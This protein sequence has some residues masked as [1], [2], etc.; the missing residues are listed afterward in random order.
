MTAQDAERVLCYS[1]LLD[2]TSREDL[3]ARHPIYSFSEKLSWPPAN[4]ASLCCWHC[5]QKLRDPPVPL[6]QDMDSASGMFI[7]YG[8]FCAFSC[9]KGYLFETQPWSAGDKL[10]LLDEMAAVVFRQERS[11]LP[12]PPRQRLTMFGG[13]LDPEQFR[14]EHQF[15]TVT[16]CPP[17]LSFPEC[18]HREAS[19]MNDKKD[20]E[21]DSR[22]SLSS[23]FAAS[24]C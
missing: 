6:P 7:V 2:D 5:C 18:Y 9:A 14:K 8:L 13:D 24:C 10:M 16:F 17:L 20:T 12:A 21:A 23:S 4:W 11:A 22:R 3:L 1:T 19:V 15:L